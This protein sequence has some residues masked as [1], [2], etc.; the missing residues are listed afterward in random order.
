MKPEQLINL[1]GKWIVLLALI[2]TSIYFATQNKMDYAGGFG[3][4]A[5]WAWW[6][7]F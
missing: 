6:F 7:L 4:G 5:F 2:G 3:V 1:A